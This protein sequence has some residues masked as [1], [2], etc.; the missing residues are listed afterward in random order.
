MI[1]ALV[2]YFVSGAVMGALAL[3]T[4]LLAT[5][6]PET[7]YVVRCSTCLQALAVEELARARESG[8]ALLSYEEV[9]ELNAIAS[10]MAIAATG[11]PPE[12]VLVTAHARNYLSLAAMLLDRRREEGQSFEL[13]QQRVAEAWRRVREHLGSPEGA[14]AQTEILVRLGVAQSE[15][16]R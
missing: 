15:R 4:A 12:D 11:R 9:E 3:T 14:R 10:A 1:S 8:P 2:F 5:K 7:G 13:H 6:P 16:L